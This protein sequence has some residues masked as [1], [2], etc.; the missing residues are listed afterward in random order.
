MKDFNQFQKHFKTYQNKFGLNG[1][2]VYF[3]HEPLEDS[4]ACISIDHRSMVATASLNNK[5]HPKHKS[6]KD[7][8]RTA[9]HEAIHLLL[10]RLEGNARYRYASESEICE[11][12]E[13]LTFKLESLIKD[14]KKEL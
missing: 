1:Y 13:E 12:V 6:F 10:G 5:L 7:I 4:F 8:K 2:R 14:W 9:K 11:S 3:K